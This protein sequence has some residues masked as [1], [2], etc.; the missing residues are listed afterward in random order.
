MSIEDSMVLSTLLGR[1]KSQEEAVVALKVF[2]QVRRPRCQK[3][4]ESSNGTGVIV[5]GQSEVGLDAAKLKQALEH[6]W[7]FIFHLDMPKHRDDAIELFEAEVKN[8]H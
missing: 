7:D 8:I 5:T 3:V 6:R 2:D 4:V 1:S